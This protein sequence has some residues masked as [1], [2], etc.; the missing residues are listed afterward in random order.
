MEGKKLFHVNA[1]QA[2]T[3]SKHKSSAMLQLNILMKFHLS[4]EAVILVMFLE[5]LTHLI[6]GPLTWQHTLMLLAASD[7]GI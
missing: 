6:S 1:W 5:I 2:M 3:S 4:L 7:A